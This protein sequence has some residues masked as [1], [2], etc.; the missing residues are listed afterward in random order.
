MARSLRILLSA[1]LL[2]SLSTAAVAPQATPAR[3]FLT[4]K[5]LVAK[6]ELM[7]SN[8]RRTVILM[9]RHDETGAFGLVVNRVVGSAPY[10]E[11]LEDMGADPEGIEGDVPIHYGGPVQPQQGFVLHSGEYDRA[12]SMRV[13]DRYAVTT[14]AEILTA[15]ARGEGPKRALFLVGYAGWAAG[16]LEGEMARGGWVVAPADEGIIFDKDYPTKWRRA[17]DSRFLKL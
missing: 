13:N 6:P 12:P 8:F 7:G 10:S 1:G 15:M 3:E 11:L 2:L 5:L 4:G 16:Q 14:D 17:F 9:V